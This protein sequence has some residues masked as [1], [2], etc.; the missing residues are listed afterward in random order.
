MKPRWYFVAGS[1]IGFAGLIGLAIAAIFLVNIVFFLVRKR[2]PGVFRLEMMLSTFPW[3][4][5]VLAVASIVIGI[6]LLRRYDFSYRKNFWLVVSAFV[7]SI[8]LAA[9]MVDYFG[10]NETWSGHGPMRRFYQQ[11]EENNAGR[12]F[13]QVRWGRRCK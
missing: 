4:V 12:P 9:W 1:F 6:L 5:V 11:I 10:I 2:G 7:A 13:D 3:W 8:L